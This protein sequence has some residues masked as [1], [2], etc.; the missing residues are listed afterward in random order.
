MEPPHQGTARGAAFGRSIRLEPDAPKTTFIFVFAL[1]GVA[2]LALLIVLVD[3]YF[4]LS[5]REEIAE[6][7]L[8]VESTN[9]RQLR[10]E[11]QAK[12]TRYQWADLKSGAVRIP[13]ERAMELTLAEWKSRPDGFVPGTPELAPAAPAKPAA[14][15][16][17][18]GPGASN[19][20]SAPA[21]AAP[22]PA[23]PAPGA[24]P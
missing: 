9:L 16:P 8:R 6:K 4:N 22:V 3:Q 10:A 14:A 19:A 15:E 7:V 20:V 2:V 13:L 24:H 17:K 5:V 1:S 12:L 21:G 23:P 18:V 11:E